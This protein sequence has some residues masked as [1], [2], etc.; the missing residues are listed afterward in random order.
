MTILCRAVFQAW[1]ACLRPQRLNQSKDQT[2]I[3][4]KIQIRKEQILFTTLYMQLKKQPILKNAILGIY[5]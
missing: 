5:S 4:Q 3:M 2:L 1:K